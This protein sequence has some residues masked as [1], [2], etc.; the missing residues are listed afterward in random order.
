MAKQ[1]EKPIVF[2][3][4]R[5]F[6]EW[7]GRHHASSAGVWVKIARPKTDHAS[8]SH[9]D[10]LAV[11]L[12][13]G[14]IDA[15]RKSLDESWWLQRFTPRGPN[16]IWSKVNRQAVE[17]LIA[18]GEMHP[19]GLAAV[20][21][22]KRNGQWDKAYDSWSNAEVPADLAAALSRAPKAR[23]FFETVS[24][25]NRYAVLFRIHTAKRAETRARRIAQF[26]A[27]LERGETI[28]P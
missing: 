25:R 24:G 3:S 14:W 4:A 9:R 26:V 13:Y 17:R 21:R 16:S 10:A 6:E 15:L 18:Q 20:E 7:L 2:P 19:A 28:Y 22:A 27:M 1:D 23:A 8:V 5:A 11:A 12:R